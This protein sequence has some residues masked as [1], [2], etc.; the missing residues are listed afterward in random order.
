MQLMLLG[1]FHGKLP[2]RFENRLE[3][4]SEVLTA[5]SGPKTQPT[6]L[7]VF[8]GPSGQPSLGSS[9]EIFMPI[10]NCTLR[11]ESHLLSISAEHSQS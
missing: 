7:G 9:E 4:C 8:N 3:K 10:V 2:G 5:R 1:M 6:L 11:C